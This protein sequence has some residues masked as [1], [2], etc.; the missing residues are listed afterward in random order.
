MKVRGERECQSCGTRW[1]Y[2]ETG[3]VACPDCGSLKSVSVSDDRE[4]HTDAPADLDLSPY[5][6]VLA[7]D[8]DLVDVAD[9]LER[10]CRAYLRRR[11]FIHAGELRPLDDRYLAVYEL[12]AAVR[13]YSRDRQMGVAYGGVDDDAVEHY[14]VSLVGGADQG[15]RPAPDEVPA[16]LTAARGLAY[17]R[18]IDS[19]REEVATYLD[20]TPDGDARRVL[21]RIRDRV[22]R[23]DAL[24]G[25]VPPGD[26]ETL[27]RACRDL[28]AYLAGD[29]GALA[30]AEDRLDR[31]T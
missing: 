14:F 21:G 31:L 18:A 2:Y 26:V 5:R 16:P 13:D 20:D 19:Y 4:R 11:G 1:S 3:E 9:D 28:Q 6:N 7:E 29:E 24:D 17:A 10:D 27:V 25:D 22:K 12:L 15:D 30:S 8:G 23:V